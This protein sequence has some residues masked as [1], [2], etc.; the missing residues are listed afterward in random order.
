MLCL[1]I[2]A[3]TVYCSD[4]TVLAENGRALLPVVLSEDAPS[5][6]V[7]AANELADYLGRISGADFSVE[8]GT[9]DSGIVFGTPGDFTQLPF[10]FAFDSG[11]FSRD[12]YLIRSTGDGLYLLGSTKGAAEYAAW[13][14]LYQF[15]YR[16]FFPTKTWEIVPRSDVLKVT[17]DRH[18][19][20][21][22]YSRRGPRGAP[23]MSRQ[24]WAQD[25]WS[26]WQVRN[27]TRSN[28]G[29]STGHV[30]CSIIRR[31][32]DVF[33]ENPEFLALV[34]GE[35][36]GGRGDKF[37]ISNDELRAFIVE[38]AVTRMMRNPD[39]DSISMDPSDGSSWCECD[40]CHEMGSVSDRVVI[41]ANEAAE[42]INELGLDGD[43]YVGI[44]AYNDY[45]PPPAVDV[46]PKVI[47]SL[48]T[49]FIRGGY[50]FDQMI[51]GWS[52][53]TNMMGIRDYYSLTVWRGFLPARGNVTSTGYLR[54]K[55]PEYHER[56]ARFMNAESDNAWGNSGLGYYLSSRILWDVGE[57][58]RVDELIDDFLVKSF[59]PASEPMRSFFLLIDRDARDPH[60]PHRRQPLNDDMLH[61]MYRYLSEARRLADGREEIQERIDDLIVYTRFVDLYRI[62]NRTRGEERQQA[63]DDLVAFT[64]RIRERVVA[65]SVN[66]LA[67]LN[68]F[69]V[70]RDDHL[71]WPEGGGRF[72]PADIHRERVDEPFSD[73]E[74]GS[75][76][77]EGMAAH[78]PLELDFTPVDY[79]DDL[80]VPAA[81]ESDAPRGTPR[82]PHF[83]V[84]NR[85]AP[86]VYIHTRDNTLPT[87]YF[88]AGHTHTDRGPMRWELVK[89]ESGETINKGEVPPEDP[90]RR[91]GWHE[92]EGTRKLELDVPQSGLYRLVIS[93]VGQGFFW[94]YEPREESMVTI[95]ADAVHPIR[96]NWLRRLYFYVPVGTREIVMY[97]ALRQRYA[98]GWHPA[99]GETIDWDDIRHE[100]GFSV[101]PVPEGRDGKLWA[102]GTRHDN[103]ELRFLN[104]PGYLAYHPSELLLPRDYAEELRERR[105]D[106]FF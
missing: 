43:K 57:A 10:E 81:T 96:R 78:D 39:A 14:L 97:G 105:D 50:T 21:D 80:L 52:E 102:F 9:G 94:D 88:S 56:G 73:E 48:A 75:L 58:E 12:E 89:V 47:V 20:P 42:A 18:E 85:A 15:G 66:M 64:W 69:F 46:H 68:R 3:V 74:M 11:P 16:Y 1:S 72:S 55:L 32:R 70:N 17:E 59:G 86:V 79:D 77:E 101:I 92:H 24:P 76:L 29:L 51:E 103:P 27:R 44:Y 35:R 63:F 71:S 87:L 106:A 37:C 53:R 82:D 91:D 7:E 67:H 95:R 65:P 100:Q 38:N 2:C 45:S 36:G 6:T 98:S 22:Y 28:F 60:V 8:T 104:I 61:R 4:E 54:D 99:E 23:R 83:A 34:G 5:E 90:P 33:D 49:S 93:N 41:L 26:K 40:P 19:K 13:D 84:G 31:N 62:M 25:G 30:Y